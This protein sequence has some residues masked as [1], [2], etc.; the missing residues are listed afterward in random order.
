MGYIKPLQI[1]LPMADTERV[2][3]QLHNVF[4]FSPEEVI[5]VHDLPDFTDV[6]CNNGLA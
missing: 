3:E 2:M 5:Q 1:D 6:P 4:G